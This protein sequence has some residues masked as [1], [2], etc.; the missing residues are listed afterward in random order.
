MSLVFKEFGA[1]GVRTVTEWHFGEPL[2]ALEADVIHLFA[3]GDELDFLVD[4]L[5]KGLPL[6]ATTKV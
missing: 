1:G 4:A 2:P 3:D 6:G 5:K